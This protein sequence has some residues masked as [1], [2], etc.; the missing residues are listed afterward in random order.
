MLHQQG[1]AP[2]TGRRPGC[3]TA[4]IWRSSRAH[5]RSRQSHNTLVLYP[6][7]QRAD[8]AAAGGADL[9][10]MQLRRSVKPYTALYQ[11]MRT[12]QCIFQMFSR[13]VVCEI[14]QVYCPLDCS[15]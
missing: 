7:L 14:Q 13:F 9:P 6:Q 10:A 3:W 8:Q 5:S 1:A 2:F 15:Q 4:I 12:L 11:P